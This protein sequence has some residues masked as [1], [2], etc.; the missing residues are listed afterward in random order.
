MKH[1]NDRSRPWVQATPEVESAA[2]VSGSQPAHNL[3]TTSSFSQ[4]M[5]KRPRPLYSAAP[6]TLSCP[7]TK[8]PLGGFAV[9]PQRFNP[10]SEAAQFNELYP[11]CS[12]CRLRAA[13]PPCVS[14]SD[15]I[16]FVMPAWRWL[17]SDLYLIGLGR[18]RFQAYQ[19]IQIWR[20]Q[21]ATNQVPAKSPNS[22]YIK[23]PFRRSE[24]KESSAG[25]H[26]AGRIALALRFGTRVI[27]G[28]IP[29][30]GSFDSLL[31]GVFHA[32]AFMFAARVRALN[33]EASAP[34]AVPPACH[35]HF[36]LL[37]MKAARR[38]AAAGMWPV[39][40]SLTSQLNSPT[41]C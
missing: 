4:G 2:P 6:A 26:H 39:R 29:G 18:F 15:T 23:P 1:P 3:P 19:R 9:N 32:R 28:Y 38:A 40:G 31:V 13:R 10:H 21:T 41:V 27:G 20:F 17:M 5:R 24:L 25:K 11:K 8:A 36:V 22:L 7:R 30:S 35:E 14:T 12:R 37:E 16:L 33:V 34:R